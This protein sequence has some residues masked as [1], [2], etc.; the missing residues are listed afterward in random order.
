[1]DTHMLKSTQKETSELLY[2]YIC[3]YMFS[4]HL[5]GSLCFEPPFL[6]AVHA[7]G[8]ASV[9]KTQTDA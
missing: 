5:W 2:V 8:L 4:L 1:M 3:I 7:I 6:L 9:E